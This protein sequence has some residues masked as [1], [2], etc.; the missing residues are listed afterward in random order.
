MD[1]KTWDGVIKKF[2]NAHVLQTWEWAEVKLKYGWKPDFHI[3]RDGEGNVEAVALIL[4]RTL[5]V[6][7]I[8]PQIQI[9]YIP[10][11]PLLDWADENLRKRVINDLC[12]Y[13]R[14]HKAI[15]LKMD[16]DLVIGNGIP[17]QKGSEENELGIKV[18][19]QI[20]NEDWHF[21]PD[22][23]QFRNT[24]WIDL[25]LSE[26][27]LLMKMKQKTRYNIR[28]AGRKG[29]KVRLATEEDFSLLYRMYVDTSIRDGFIIRPKE[30]Y[31]WVWN[32]FIKADM[33]K[34][35][36]AEVDDEPVAGLFLFYL[37]KK[38]WYLYGMSTLKHRQKMPNYLLQWEAIKLA[39]SLGC[40]VYDLW[41]APDY[42]NENDHMWGV[43]RFKIGLGGRVVRT[44]GAW[45][46]T[47]LP[48]WYSA[49]HQIMPRVLNLTRTIRRKEIQNEL[50]LN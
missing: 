32:K 31:L 1:K 27:D 50:N 43:F 42:F 30:Y 21:S 10:R 29:V 41:G 2:A 38:A 33:A 45:D 37:G 14:E 20:Q 9:C 39:K 4:Q 17:G 22:Q 7:K 24:V 11:G 48:F 46:Y 26:N 5:R 44:I 23:I 25:T 28:L 3:W 13:A 19:E 12:L 40:E 47:S 15:F 8:G 16:P 34:A 6:F 18:R 36:I 49:Y 35:L